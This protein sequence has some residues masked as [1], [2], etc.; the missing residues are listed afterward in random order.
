MGLGSLT[1]IAVGFGV[2]CRKDPIAHTAAAMNNLAGDRVFLS[3]RQSMA[4]FPEAV[5]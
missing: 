1:G 2:E 3:Q 4:A 5:G